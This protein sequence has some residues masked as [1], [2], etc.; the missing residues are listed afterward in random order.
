MSAH[1]ALRQ[2]AS[3]SEPRNSEPGAVMSGEV[4]Q[5]LIVDD[6]GDLAPWLRSMIER[7]SRIDGFLGV[8]CFRSADGR[9]VV[10]G[11]RWLDIDAMSA[12]ALSNAARRHPGADRDEEP[13]VLF[14]GNDSQRFELQIDV[15][16]LLAPR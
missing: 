12:A 8:R 2:V 7:A 1:V 4:L 13:I 3:H 11:M 10:I 9:R 6:G 5:L 16:A 15:P 14:L